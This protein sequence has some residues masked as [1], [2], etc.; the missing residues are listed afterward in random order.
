MPRWEPDRRL[1]APRRRSAG[2]DA[3]EDALRVR[4]TGRRGAVPQR[5]RP[6]PAGQAGQDHR[7]GRGDRVDSLAVRHRP[8]PA[9][10]HRPPCPRPAV[11]TDRKAPPGAPAPD[12]C[13]KT[14]RARLSYRRAEEIVE[15]NTRLPADP[16]A[17]P[18]D[19]EELDDW[20]LHRLWHSTVTYDAENGT[21][22]PMLLARSR[23]ASVRALERYARPGVDSVARHVAERDPAARRRTQ[24]RADQVSKIIPLLLWRISVT[25]LSLP[26][27]RQRLLELGPHGDAGADLLAEDLVEGDAVP[28]ERVEPAVEFL[29]EGRAARVADASVRARQVR[30]DPRRRRGVRAP[31]PAPAAPSSGGDPW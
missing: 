19:V 9:P 29:P 27:G 13:P 24:I 6:L 8:A 7:Q 18:D 25:P 23:H 3:V 31:R 4:R 20:T 12:A 30:V 28:R 21:S 22:A 16:L 1:V 15:E 26:R 17:S 11:P 2:E 14:G 10:P 5:G